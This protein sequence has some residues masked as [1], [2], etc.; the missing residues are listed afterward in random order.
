MYVTEVTLSILSIGI[1]TVCIA[2]SRAQVFCLTSY[3]AAKF[4]AVFS[5]HTPCDSFVG[6]YE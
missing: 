3:K 1:D 5:V 6:V 4:T 2:L